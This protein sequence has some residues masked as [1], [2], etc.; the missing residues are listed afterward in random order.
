[1]MRE[2][3]QVLVVEDS[4]TQALK[5]CALLEEEGLATAHRDSA[6]NALDF[7]SEHQPDLIVIDYHLPGMSGP[8]LCRQLRMNSSTESV[9]LL[10]MTGDTET[11]VER[12]GLE[13]GADD[14][15]PK[16]M[17]AD[18]LMARI[19]VLLRQ[20]R[21][22]NRANEAAFFRKLR[23]LAV[24]DSPT[25][26][27]FLEHAI[28]QE[29]YSVETA[30]NGD[31]AL[32][33]LQKQ[34]FDCMLIDLVMPGMDG[35]QLCQKLDEYR[36]RANLNLPI[37]M[38]TNKDSRDDMMRA[39]EAGADDFISKSN[40]DTILKARIRTMLRRKI[41]LDEHERI[42]NEFH[43]KEL[44]VLRERAM[45]EAAEAKAAMAE[46]LEKAN[47]EIREKHAQLKEA[48]SQLI[49]SAKMASLGELVAGIAH[50]IN[51]PM[52]FII[53]H[54]DTVHR[55]LDKIMPTALPHLDEAQRKGAEKV[56]RRLEDIAEGLQRVKDLVVKLRTFSR[57]D[58]GES[59]YCNIHDGIESVL[60]ML[61]HKHK[62]RIEIV[63]DYGERSS[64]TCQPG[65]LNQV[66]MNLI[67]NAIDAIEGP[68]RVTI[69][70]WDNVENF[71]VSIADTGT[72]IPNEIRER[73]FEPFFT[74]KTV[75]DG[76][77]LGLAISYRIIT[78]LKG[79]ITVDTNQDGGTVFTLSVPIPKEEQ[80]HEK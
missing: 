24:D 48:Q 1:M 23:L 11:N 17:D 62:D 27:A 44:E 30:N 36:S 76:T 69:Q 20:T 6:E 52:S 53:S 8:E 65:Q 37:M 55:H 35:I 58:E 72:G 25:Y 40:D 26:L 64:F 33:R 51:N 9:P 71:Y 57:I 2:G 39:L 43:T 66:F 10:M 75:G 67:G 79:E 46:K 41:L 29:G 42:N 7:L 61:H 47:E 4:A 59:K 13:S 12:R 38:I 28:Q 5:L 68:G 22:A 63:R 60:M 77:G 56:D 49:Q 73:I 16:S 50:E 14:H 18:A 80:S 78:S 32:E 3:K 19:H 31:E 70:T 34:H 54:L 21:K 74:T 45:K 15:I